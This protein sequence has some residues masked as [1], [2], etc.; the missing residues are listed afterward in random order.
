MTEFDELL[1]EADSHIMSELG[2]P[3]TYLRK[4]VDNRIATRVIVDRDIQVMGQYADVIELQT[5]GSLLVADVGQAGRGDVIIFAD[6]AYHVR[7]PVSNDGSIIQVELLP[8]P[9]LHLG[10]QAMEP[11]GHL[12]QFVQHEW[13]AL[14]QAISTLRSV[15]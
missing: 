5:Q 10:L 1:A 7:K 9:E 15:Q 3:C 8:D 14:W 12:N 4:S 13:S 6:M 11:M 2:Q